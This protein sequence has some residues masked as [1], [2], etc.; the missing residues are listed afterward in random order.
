MGLQRLQNT[1][2]SVTYAHSVLVLCS[3]G[4]VAVFREPANT[5]IVSA[6]VTMSS[7]S[8]VELCMSSCSCRVV[9]AEFLRQM[10]FL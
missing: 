1:I 4:T 10:S 3:G 8:H 2:V 7:E 5:G 6:M 9:H